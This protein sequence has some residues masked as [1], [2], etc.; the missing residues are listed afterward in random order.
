MWRIIFLLLPIIG[1]SYV[2]WHVW[3]VI[4]LS[5]VWKGVAVVLL[6]A[7][8]FSLFLNFTGATDKYPLPVARGVYEVSTSSIM[9]LMYL[10]IVFV[11]L[12]LG[13]LVSLVPKAV[14]Y[15]NAR[16]SV[17]IFVV[18]LFV[19]VYGNINYNDKKRVALELRTEKPLVKDYRI[20]MAT[21][22]HIGYHNP[23]KELA[24]WIDMIND[25][26][27]DF[28][29][30]GGDI[31]D[32]RIRPLIE[33]NMAAEFRRLNA[34]VYAVLGNHE[35]I[36]GK[37]GSERFYRKAGIHLL[38]DETT[39]IDSCIV[40]VGRNDRFAGKRKTLKDLMKG[41]DKSKYIIL[42]DHQPYNLEQAEREGVDFQLS[43][44]THRGQMWPISWVT[45]AMYECSWGSHQRGDTQYY[46]SSGLGIWGGKFRI[47]TQSEYVVARVGKNQELSVAAS[48]K[49]FLG[50]NY[51]K[52]ATNL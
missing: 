12:D 8:V 15:D 51:H 11:C 10:V 9:V 23:R 18:L 13:R 37:D 47:G 52:F 29:L 42:L 50:M 2:G 19:F 7:S 44:H 46:V 27:P 3:N 5:K 6:V 36:S 22:L 30:I 48:L 40:I 33:E 35:Y 24:R 4:P 26:K 16:T 17:G 45:D 41:I 1:I 43:G 20:V 39:E 28:I 31:I 38:V 25:E 14:L 49:E 32:G 34:P 21:D